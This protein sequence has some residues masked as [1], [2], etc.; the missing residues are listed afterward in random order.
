MDIEQLKGKLKN[1]GFCDYETSILVFLQ[2]QKDY[3]SVKEI[4]AG[5]KVPMGRIYSILIELNNEGFVKRMPGK[6]VKYKIENK[7]RFI[8]KIINKNTDELK[9]KQKQIMS[10]ANFLKKTLSKLAFSSANEIEVNY[11]TDDD[12]YWKTY[13]NATHKLKKGDTY[14]IINSR[15]LSDSLLNSELKDNPKLKKMINSDNKLIK[16]GVKFSL[17][18]NPKSIVE[19]TINELENKADIKV[20]LNQLLK[21]FKHNKIT[22][23]LFITLESN[24]QS[25]IFVILKEDV[26]IE[27]YNK[28]TNSIASA[29][30]IRSS[31]VVQDMSVWFDS[32]NK[33]RN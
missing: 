15:R 5:S 22:N 33:K 20:A 1:L 16:K 10:D 6:S 4:M 13:L 31:K 18:T 28:K 11:F 2:G 14:R 25:L 27:F 26:F 23:N 9:E 17:V 32:F 3:V 21:V 30:H 7:N 19:N 12:S 29:I 24:L 8:K